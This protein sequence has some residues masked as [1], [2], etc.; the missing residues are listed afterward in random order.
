MDSIPTTKTCRTCIVT[1]ERAEFYDAKK[2]ADGKFSECK[3]CTKA[4]SRDRYQVTLPQRHAYEHARSRRPERKLHITS[5]TRKHRER[6]PEKYAARTAVGNAIRDGRLV[7]GPCRHCR[8]TVRVQAHHHDYSK[9]L[10]VEW[11]CFRCHRE[12]EHGQT[13]TAPDDGR[14][15]P[16]G[17]RPG[18]IPP[19]QDPPAPP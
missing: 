10:D 4:R 12:V 16:G 3:D 18:S 8:T 17:G 7:R 11:E 14:G 19:P 1:K 2:A 6:H 5:A 15:P 9:P 13:V